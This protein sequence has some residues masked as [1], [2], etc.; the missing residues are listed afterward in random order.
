MALVA[1]VNTEKKYGRIKIV[2]ITNFLKMSQGERGRV[3]KGSFDGVVRAQKLALS[4][5]VVGLVQYA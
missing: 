4:P 5:K 3:S 1:K 2:K